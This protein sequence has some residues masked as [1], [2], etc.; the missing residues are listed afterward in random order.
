MDNTYFS[1]VYYTIVFTIAY[2]S[3]R[4]SGRTPRT[5]W[6]STRTLSK[7]PGSYKLSTANTFELLPFQYD[8]LRII[9]LPILSNSN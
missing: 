9:Y 1:L 5:E 4:N 7:K 3:K 6:E 2:F 8:G